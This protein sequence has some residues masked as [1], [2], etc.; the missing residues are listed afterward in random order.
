MLE[1]RAPPRGPPAAAGVA[2]ADD[3]GWGGRCTLLGP[4]RTAAGVD[5]AVAVEGPPLPTP[6]GA[7]V[8][9]AEGQ[10]GEPAPTLLLLL[11]RRGVAPW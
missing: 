2:F 3:V 11:S 1:E 5:V 10:E 8:V 4:R 7:G 6:L 9:K